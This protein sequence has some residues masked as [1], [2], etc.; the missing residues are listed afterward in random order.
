MINALK[1]NDTFVNAHFQ[2]TP[3]VD[4]IEY[5]MQLKK[6]YNVPIVSNKSKIL[7][8]HANNCSIYTIKS[9]QS[10]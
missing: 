1:A 7:H 8:V 2:F 5:I 6:Y 4:E 10:R 3:M 9:L